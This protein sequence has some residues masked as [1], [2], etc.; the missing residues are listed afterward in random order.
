MIFFFLKLSSPLTP[1]PFHVFTMPLKR[2]DAFLELSDPN[3]IL[4][5]HKH[6]STE[7]VLGN[8]DPLA[9]KRARNVDVSTDVSTA[10]TVS[11]ASRDK[12]NHR[13]SLMAPLTHLT[14]TT[15]PLTSSQSTCSTNSTKSGNDQTSDEASNEA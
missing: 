11:N 9:C 7:C 14:H 6:H 10:T 1:V 8:G 5:P 3:I 4:G 12:E 15:S 13:L 2:S